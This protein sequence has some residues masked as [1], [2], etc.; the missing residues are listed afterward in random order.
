[1]VPYCRPP[2]FCGFYV[3]GGV[4][5]SFIN[6]RH[7]TRITNIAPGTD[8]P[9]FGL[10]THNINGYLNRKT[11]RILAWGG[12]SLPFNCLCAPL[13][14]ALE[15]FVQY[16]HEVGR[17]SGEALF[18]DDFNASVFT[19]NVSGSA[20]SQ[21]R[22]FQW[23]FQARPGIFLNRTTLAYATL[24]V[25]FARLKARYN[26]EYDN[27]SDGAGVTIPFTIENH[28]SHAAFRV[29]GGLEYALRW[30]GLH[31]RADYVH[32]NYRSLRMDGAI[33]EFV[34]NTIGTVSLS[35]DSHITYRDHA[36]T[37]GLNK[38]L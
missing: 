25:S 31:L 11:P 27:P 7:K 34:D 22:P 10:H 33:S 37:I 1:M 20:S 13:F 17:A 32:T 15:A 26:L 36:F 12:Y 14:T 35:S 21:V 16:Q 24:G 6:Q 23:G 4:G 18:I 8:T 2:E 38:Y 3:G 30:C 28:K 29:G 19:A 9:E 5:G